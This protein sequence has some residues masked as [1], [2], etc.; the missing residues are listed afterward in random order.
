MFCAINSRIRVAA[1]RISLSA[2]S[3]ASS[4]TAFK[5]YLSLRNRLNWMTRSPGRSSPRL[6]TQIRGAS[7][8]S[9]GFLGLDAMIDWLFRY[10]IRFHDD[11]LGIAV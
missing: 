7:L 4:S 6:I 3:D 9:Y 11:D 5:S 8:M 2:D 1:C 10:V